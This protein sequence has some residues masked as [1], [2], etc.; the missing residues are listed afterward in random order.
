MELLPIFYNFVITKTLNLSKK[1]S[2]AGLILKQKNIKS[3]MG[4]L[5]QYS[6]RSVEKLGAV[7][8][9]YG[10]RALF[11]FCNHQDNISKSQE[12]KNWCS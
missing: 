7:L 2:V 11:L 8:Q 4:Q 3:S 1:V 9:I 5:Y 6:T 12:I 10:A